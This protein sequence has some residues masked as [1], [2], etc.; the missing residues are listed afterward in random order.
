MIGKGFYREHVLPRLDAAAAGIL[1]EFNV[2]KVAGAYRLDCPACKE[3][4]AAYYYPTHSCVVC[5]RKNNCGVNTTIWNIVAASV[6]DDGKATF[7]KL[8][9]K[10]G[11]SPPDPTQLD[12]G[13][14]ARYKIKEI[15]RDL[16]ACSPE[17]MKYLTETRGFCATVIPQMDIGYYPSAAV[18]R[19]AL[20]SKNIPLGLAVEW[21]ILPPEDNRES[22][23]RARIIGYWDQL[24]GSFRLWGRSIHDSAEH[25]YHF[26]TGLR[27]HLPYLFRRNKPDPLPCVEGPFDAFSLEAV[28]IPACASGGASITRVQAQNLKSSGIE[29]IVYMIDRDASGENGA[30]NSIENCESLGIAVYLCCPTV[31]FKDVDEMRKA[32]K[33]DEIRQLIDDAESAGRFLASI[34]IAR[35]DAKV[36]TAPLA[37][38]LIRLR[39]LLTTRSAIAFDHTLA[40]AGVRLTSPESQALQTARNLID[41]GYAPDEACRIA[42]GPFGLTLSISKAA[43]V[44]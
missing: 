12:A 5:N 31:G 25:K 41:A 1:D 4:G 26:A 38:E 24:D 35:I 28:G 27:K 3:K 21:G 14:R 11:V 15:F 2:R 30:M 42:A 36:A 9:E 40:A 10:A 34:Y 43:E 17:A 23:F 20:Q 6:G 19:D 16:L 22:A 29:S 13:T 8:C 18:V 44:P 37:R 33:V 7:L 32:G 39:A